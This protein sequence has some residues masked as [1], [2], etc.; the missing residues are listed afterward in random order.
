MSETMKTIH[1]GMHTIEAGATLSFTLQ[2]AASLHV[3]AGLIWLT[4]AGDEYDYWLGADEKISLAAGQHIVIES[5]R[6]VSC[7]RLQMRAAPGE[8]GLEPGLVTA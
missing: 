4:I 1:S 2:G 3:Q 5:D 7:L 6:G 8:P